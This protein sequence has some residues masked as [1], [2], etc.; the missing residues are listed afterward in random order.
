MKYLKLNFGFLAV[1]ATTLLVSCSN[2]DNREQTKPVVVEFGEAPSSSLITTGVVNVIT[3]NTVRYHTIDFAAAPY[4]VTIVETEDNIVLVDLGPAPAFADELETYVDAINKTGAVIITH[5]HGDHYGGAGNFTDLN[6]YAENTVAD[7][8]NNTDDFTSLYSNSV[9]GVSGSQEIGG[10]T[11]TFDKV[12]NAETGENSFLYNEELKIVFSG[13][14]VYNL[15]HPYLREYTPNAGEDEIDNW[16]AGLNVLKTNF[17][18]Y[19]HLFVGHNGSR[20]DIGT[21]IDEN[22][23]YLQTAQGLIKGSETISR[24]G[25][26]SNQQEV[27]DE[28]ELR[29]PNHLEGGIFL[30]L[31]DAFFPGDPGANWF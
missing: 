22:I 6:F 30:S 16:V 26:A 25:A 9:I 11:F 19:S 23:D 13:D 10:L 15:T 1:I 4:T 8:L 29:Y 17:S 5:N 12:S 24:G 2:D 7:Q 31:P 14:L 3:E 21:V 20:N 28:L 18:G 27:V